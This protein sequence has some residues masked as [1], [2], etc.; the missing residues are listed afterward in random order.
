MINPV[1]DRRRTYLGIAI[2]AVVALLVVVLPRGGDVVTL[3][4]G[5]LQAAFLAALAVM[6]AR[7]YRTHSSWLNALSER[8]RGLLYGAISVAVL[9]ITA[10]DRFRSAGGG[11]RLLEFAIVGACAGTC[12][13]IWRESR[14]YSF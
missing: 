4:S 12:Y 2:I 5:A 7:L 11:L 14:R 13:W 6:G 9:T 8:D 1:S 10:D 3:A